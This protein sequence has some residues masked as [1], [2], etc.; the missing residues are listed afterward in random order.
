MWATCVSLWC[1]T[2]LGGV[3]ALPMSDYWSQRADMIEAEDKLALGGRL[4]FQQGERIV[5]DILMS[6]K[7]EELSQGSHALL[8]YVNAR[9]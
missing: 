5:D 4:Q 2:L 9:L 8:Y 7:R 6:A 1:I 3:F